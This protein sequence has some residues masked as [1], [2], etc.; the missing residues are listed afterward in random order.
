M[1]NISID[2]ALLKLKESERSLLISSLLLKI[3]KIPNSGP[4]ANSQLYLSIKITCLLAS[5][6]AVNA[7]LILTQPDDLIVSLLCALDTHFIEAPHAVKEFVIC[8]L[9][10]LC[11]ADNGSKLCWAML[12]SNYDFIFNFAHRPL[13][14]LYQCSNSLTYKAWVLLGYQGFVS[15]VFAIRDFKY[16]NW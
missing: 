10:A 2:L 11:S 3:L 1:S 6:S 8:T 9:Y 12:H 16:L 5:H 13:L 4:V 15:F 14:V 7:S